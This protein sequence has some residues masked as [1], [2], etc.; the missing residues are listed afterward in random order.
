M[1]YRIYIFCITVLAFWLSA[2]GQTYSDKIVRSY[3]INKTSSIDVSNKYG[4][5]HVVKWDK[6][7]VKFE[8]DF[9]IKTSTAGKLDRI[10]NSIDFDFTGTEYYVTAKTK[11][12]TSRGIISDFMNSVLSVDMNQIIIDYLV[13]IPDYVSIRIE[14]KFGDVYIDDLNGN[15]DLNLSNGDFK[16]NNLNGS[17]L[18]NIGLGDGTINYMN[19]GKLYISYS[20]F[21]IKK[22]NR[23]NIESRSS[24]VYADNIKYLK[25]I[26][27][28]D[29]IYITNIDQFLGDSYFSDISIQKLNKELNYSF[30]YGEL[31][32]NSIN[33]KFSFI[34]INSEYTDVNLIFETGSYY[35]VDITH[36]EDVY[37]FYPRDISKLEEKMIDKDEKLLLTYGQIGKPTTDAIPKLKIDALKKCTINITHK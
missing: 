17:S 35:D 10:K 13:Y 8:V 32:I 22:S 2:N 34:N 26:S 18:I 29:K 27:R 3:K 4:K 25:L 15:L 20:D 9:S 5:I 19:K 16:A 6:D 36:S 11:F 23:L 37:L 7:S 31:S 24:K 28:R 33:N 21:H 1:N 12:L 30:K 14:N